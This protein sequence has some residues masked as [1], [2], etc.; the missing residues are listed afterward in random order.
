MHLGDDDALAVEEP[1]HDPG[2]IPTHKQELAV[3][4]QYIH[5]AGLKEKGPFWAGDPSPT[6][7]IGFFHQGMVFEGIHNVLGQPIPMLVDIT[8]IR[9]EE[10]IPYH[11]LV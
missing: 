5:P 1:F 10:E 6:I 7:E 2:L 9:P 8:T 11:V 3:T 4:P